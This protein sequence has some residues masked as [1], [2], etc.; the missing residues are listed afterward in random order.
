MDVPI[1]EEAP[2]IVN[3]IIEIPRKSRIK[4]EMDEEK[5]FIKV[6]R[7]V[8]AAMHYPENYGLLPQTH[9]DDG[10][11]LDMLVVSSEAFHPWTV[12]RAR[13]VGVLNMKDEAGIDP[14]LVGVAVDDPEYSDIKSHEDLPQFKLDMIGHF[15]A[16]YKDLEKGKFAEVAGWDGAD[17]AKE[18]IK[19]GI[20]AAK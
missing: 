13:P 15:F 20:E 11:A 1:G 19:E 5:G 16:R 3:C 14:K 10:D 2:E 12:V 6:D 8:N 4:Y 17:K 9:A 18:M 7:I